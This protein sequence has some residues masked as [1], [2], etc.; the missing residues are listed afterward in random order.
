VRVARSGCL[1][2]RFE[3]WKGLDLWGDMRNDLN[4]C[5]VPTREI[6]EWVYTL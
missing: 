6:V 4:K 2:G 5:T 3:E 1:G